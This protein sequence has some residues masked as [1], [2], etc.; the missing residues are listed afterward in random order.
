MNFKFY[1]IECGQAL[2]FVNQ[3]GEDVLMNE[4]S[5]GDYFGEKALVEHTPRTATIKVIYI[6]LYQSPSGWVE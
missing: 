5:E 6:S 4:L 3:D 2:A 1:F